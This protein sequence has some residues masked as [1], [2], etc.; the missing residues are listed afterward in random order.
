MQNHV[1]CSTDSY[2]V[3]KMDEVFKDIAA[4]G[5]K[6]I[7]VS[8]SQTR[9]PGIVPECLFNFRHNYPD[10]GWGKFSLPDLAEWLHSFGLKAE[11]M[12]A[13]CEL[14][15]PRSVEWLRRRIDASKF[16]G[17]DVLST[18]IGRG[19]EQAEARDIVRDNL[20]MAC[21]YAEECGKIICVKTDAWLA[22]GAD[23]MLRFMDGVKS[24]HLKI[25]F[26]PSLILYHNP[27]ADLTNYLKEIAR[28]V[29][30]VHLR[31]IMKKNGRSELPQDGSCPVNYRKLF[32][33]LNENGFYGPFCLETDYAYFW[34][35]SSAQI[36]LTHG[37]WQAPWAFD[38]AGLRERSKKI[39]EFLTAYD[40]QPG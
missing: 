19:G 37:S 38:S 7:E 34:E 22:E 17:I 35:P 12:N 1:L 9:P 27:D 36:P 25:D 30:C 39:R 40:L 16:L 24:E 33:L 23:E 14:C 21:R 5:F 10:S 29:G 2:G 32:S 31:G 13:S 15:H 18:G 20:Q 28:L 4:I 3:N 6:S 26:D 8:C 11:V